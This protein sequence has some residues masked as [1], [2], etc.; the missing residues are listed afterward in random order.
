MRYSRRE[1]LRSFLDPQ[2]LTGEDGASGVS[3]GE[4]GIRLHSDR[5]LAWQRTVCD[6]CREVCP[7]A[8]I[9]FEGLF[10]PRIVQEACTYCGEC[11]TDCPT[12]ALQITAP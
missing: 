5:C 12:A 11:V 4:V 9:V 2:H 7:E 8:A 1:L 10:E 3:T 6:V